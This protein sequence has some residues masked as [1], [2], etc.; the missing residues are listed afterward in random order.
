MVVEATPWAPAELGEVSE[1]AAMEAKMVAAE[2]ASNGDWA[3]AVAAYSKAIAGNPSAL[4]YA[5]RAEALIKMGVPQAHAHAH[6]MCAFHAHP[7][8]RDP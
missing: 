7:C 2:A 5:K 8:T 1:D 3:A 4:T 6:N